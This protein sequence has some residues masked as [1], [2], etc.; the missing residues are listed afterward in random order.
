[1][2]KTRGPAMMT[3]AIL[4][5]SLTRRRLLAGV[6][7]AA[8]LLLG[9][10]NIAA[11]RAQDSGAGSISVQGLLCP[12]ATSDTSDCQYT[13][14]IFNGDISISTPNG[15]ILTLDDGESHAVSHVWEGLDDGTYYLQALGAS[16]SGYA[17]DHIDGA[18]VVDS[19]V[20]AIVVSDDNPNVSVTL[21]YVANS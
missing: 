4:A 8:A 16:P 2:S 21:V 9:P 7:G 19:G 14:E 13:D 15:G 5:S 12:T 1:M 18:S 6:S 20:E 3:L 17:L 11:V 10:V